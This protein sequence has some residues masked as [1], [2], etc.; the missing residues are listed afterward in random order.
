MAKSTLIKE[1]TFRGLV[2][3]H[4]EEQGSMQV[5]TGVLAEGYIWIHRPRKGNWAWHG[6]L[7]LKIHPQWHTSSDK[8][9]P[10]NPSQTVPLTGD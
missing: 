8:A 1:S 9:T 5:G 7:K 4:T 2:H 10:P 6:F 3:Y